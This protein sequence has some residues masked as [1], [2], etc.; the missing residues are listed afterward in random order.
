M[1]IRPTRL[2][3]QAHQ[4]TLE[5]AQGTNI[6]LG[7]GALS[8]ADGF[9]RHDPPLPHELERAIDAVEDALMADHVPRAIGGSLVSSG[10]AL[11]TLPGLQTSGAMVSRD[12]IE[13]LFQRLAAASL[14]RP[15][16][17]SGLPK[18]REAAAALLIMRECMHHLGF[19]S[20]SFIGLSQDRSPH[21]PGDRR[22]WRR[23]DHGSA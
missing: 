9:F 11:R 1:T 6:I 21:A 18:G 14:G 23:S 5:T 4:T 22:R 7:V 15:G 19:E 16:H 3:L 12:H 2:H 17:M 8:V 13:A 10:P 20:V